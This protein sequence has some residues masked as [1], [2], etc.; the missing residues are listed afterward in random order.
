[1]TSPDQ[2]PI[3]PGS[4]DHH[5]VPDGEGGDDAAVGPEFA[6][7]VWPHETE[8][9]DEPELSVRRRATVA[10]VV[11]V[12]VAVLGFGLGLIW[13]HVSPRVPIMKVE[14]G[15]VYADA[16]P[17][18]AVAADGWFL[19]IGIGLGLVLAVAAWLLLRRHRGVPVLLALTVGSLLCAWVAWWLGHRIGIMQFNRASAHA[20]I[21]ARLQ[22]PIELGMT[23]MDP[24]RSWFPGFT[25]VIVGQAFAAAVVYS[26]LAGFSA[27]ENLRGPGRR[28]PLP[29]PAG[30]LDGGEI[31][32]TG[33][34]SYPA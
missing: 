19:I 34:S 3:V 27:Y 1:M 18:Q 33:P 9:P 7:Y 15:Y 17:E 31:P 30:P 4:A 8:P 24:H 2:P 5:A 28:A 10:V 16:E 25:G 11:A 6:R 29:E 26:A 13:L 22:A 20:P 14:G 32:D 12:V 21:G 23:N